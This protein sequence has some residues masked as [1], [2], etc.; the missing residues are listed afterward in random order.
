MGLKVQPDLHVTMKLK[1]LLLRINLTISTLFTRRLN[2]VR[3]KGTRRKREMDVTF[4]SEL[5]TKGTREPAPQIG[6]SHEYSRN[7]KCST[8]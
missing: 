1:R 2:R 5:L 3:W 7:T 4:G 6:V 8:R